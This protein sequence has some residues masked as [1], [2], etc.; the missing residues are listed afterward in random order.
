MIRILLPLFAVILAI[1]CLFL[2]GRG[3]AA[4]EDPVAVAAILFLVAVGCFPLLR[5]AIVATPER[6]GAWSGCNGDCNRRG[7]GCF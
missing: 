7:G 3:L 2:S 4:L 5:R 1:G 6:N